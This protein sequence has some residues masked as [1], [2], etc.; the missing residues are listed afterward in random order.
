MKEFNE[1]L[2]NG[3]KIIENRDITMGYQVA[4]SWASQNKWQ[5]YTM[6]KIEAF[7]NGTESKRKSNNQVLYVLGEN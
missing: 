3:A 4:K 5:N 7:L 2:K 1:L 6:D